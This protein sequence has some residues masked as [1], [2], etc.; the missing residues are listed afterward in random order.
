MRRLA[1][2]LVA[3]L[4]LSSCSSDGDDRES[5][6]TPSS[7]SSPSPSPSPVAAPP[8]PAAPGA[9]ACYRLSYGEA[10]A[11]TNTDAALPCSRRHTS[12]TFAVGQLD[13]VANG[14]LLAVDSAA[15]LEQVAKRCPGQLA[16][17]LGATPE[18]LR[19]SLLRPVWFTPTIEESDA[20]AGWYR[21][22]VIAVTGERTLA[23]FERDLAGALAQPDGRGDLATCGTDE[24]GS[25]AFR[26]V[27]CRDDHTWKAISVLDL[28]DR[29]EGGRYPGEKVVQQAGQDPC[30][31][32]ARA[33]A[34]DA[35]DY[36]WGYEWPTKDQWE[37]GQTYG[38]C[39]SPDPA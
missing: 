17:Y 27:L 10:L 14:H 20:G 37:A 35:L 30:A 23:T 16:A 7:S 38:R 8:P 9:G 29:S 34:S 28:A 21:C 11:P 12:Q 1:L 6:A 36:E 4:A 15:V 25:A 13:L 33:I 5:E 31:E 32:E 26:H 19:L 2:L 22:D 39:W 24:P 18:Q 3:A